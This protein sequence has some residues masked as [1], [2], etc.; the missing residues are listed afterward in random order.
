MSAYVSGD[1]CSAF[2]TNNSVNMCP[3]ILT[4]QQVVVKGYHECP[5][6]IEVGER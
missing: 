5:F 6:S 2:C 1:F 4:I 3:V